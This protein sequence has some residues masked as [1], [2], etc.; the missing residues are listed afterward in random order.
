LTSTNHSQSGTPG[1]GPP[2]WQTLS[3]QRASVESVHARYQPRMDASPSR[4]P[5]G[6]SSISYCPNIQYSRLHSNRR[7]R[8][9]HRHPRRRPQHHAL[10]QPGLE[11]HEVRN[12]HHLYNS[13]PG[14][15]NKAGGMEGSR[16]RKCP[17]GGSGSQKGLPGGSPPAPPLR[18]AEVTLLPPL[19][20]T[21]ARSYT[22]KRPR[23][24]FC[25]VTTTYSSNKTTNNPSPL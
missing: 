9:E 7:R 8:C 2:R 25:I 4:F 22:T 21:C 17:C 15:L 19:C 12:G 10:R 13:E 5:L 16:R 3:T 14:G 1:P 20:R 24:L 23:T 6:F 18:P 11:H